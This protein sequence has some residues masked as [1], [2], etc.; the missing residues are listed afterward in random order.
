MS[1]DEL[2]TLDLIEVFKRIH[3]LGYDVYLKM[4]RYQWA[5]YIIQA[6]KIRIKVERRVGELSDSTDPED[7]EELSNLRNL[8]DI[9]QTV[10]NNLM[11]LDPSPL[12]IPKG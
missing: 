5:E 12:P 6:M 11:K 1:K 7:K 8:R 9:L 2:N 10:I 4:P 3:E